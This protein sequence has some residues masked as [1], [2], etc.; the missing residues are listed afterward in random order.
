MITPF[1]DILVRWKKASW[2]YIYLNSDI[3]SCEP[4]ITMLKS[5]LLKSSYWYHLV[6]MDHRFT[7][8]V[9][10]ILQN[11][12]CYVEICSLQV[13]SRHPCTTSASV[14][15]YVQDKHFVWNLEWFTGFSFLKHNWT[16]ITYFVVDSPILFYSN[17]YQRDRTSSTT[18]RLAT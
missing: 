16:A 13:T 6:L 12:L 2:Y 15:V 8:E 9:C 1:N 7:G 11:I 17:R 5:V 14:S 10:D 3:L 4:L 18:L